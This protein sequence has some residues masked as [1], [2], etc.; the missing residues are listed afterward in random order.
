MKITIFGTG[1]VGLVT[2]VCL[3]EIGH[4]V[5]CVDVDEKKI[6][7]LNSGEVPIYEPGLEDL[8]KKNRSSLE[9]TTN[10]QKAIKEAEVIFIAVGTPQ[11]EDG[12]ADLR[13]V[14]S[15]AKTLGENM[16]APKVIVVKSTVPV[17]SEV[18]VK[19]IISKNFKGKFSIVSNPEFL[20]EGSAIQDFM[21]PDRIIIGTNEEEAADKLVEVYK[22]LNAPIIHTDIRS[23]QL[24]KYASNAFLATK[25]SF[26]NEM[27]NLAEKF[28]AN[29]EFIAKGM[30]YDKRI[31]EQFLKAG[32]GYGGSCFPK[33]VKEILHTA[34]SKGIEL[35]VLEEVDEVNEHQKHVPVKKLKAKLDLKGTTVAVLGLAF[36]P[37]T[38]DIREAASLTVIQDL[39]DNGVKVRA[40][41][42]IA[43]EH[44]RKL[45]P[46]I[47]YVD[48]LYQAIDGVDALIVV[49]EWD[50]IKNLDLE[51]VKGLMKTPIIVDGR[52]ALNMKQAKEL[53][54][55]YQGIGR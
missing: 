31:G 44:V 48:D 26:I 35:E 49:T 3:A 2:G 7:R 34:K 16:D 10:G 53:G 29:I 37:N 27:A 4:T 50:E 19:E 9:F 11:M 25:I 13:F 20:R 40:Y 17:G 18:E 1:Y 12:S 33:D 14:H 23:A 51:K 15:V 46:D 55:D 38:D 6:E 8:V 54:F 52:N 39:L 43:K 28:D 21:N 32:I 22:P 24:I 45:F 42:P 5:T 41:D 47:E 36:K 30:G